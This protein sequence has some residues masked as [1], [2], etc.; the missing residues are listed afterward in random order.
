[1]LVQL[2]DGIPPHADELKSIIDCFKSSMPRAT[3]HAVY[4]IQNAE[5]YRKYERRKK[6]LQQSHTELTEY[7]HVYHGTKANPPSL[8][9]E[10]DI[11]F[12]PSKCINHLGRVSTYACVHTAAVVSGAIRRALTLILCARACH[13]S[14][15]SAVLDGELVCW[16]GFVQLPLYAVRTSGQVDATTER[17]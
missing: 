14:Q 10:S 15:S 6:E 9:Y 17:T 7:A 2:H 8:I 11:G 1:V 13:G 3:V 4:R 5:L 12:D 16:F